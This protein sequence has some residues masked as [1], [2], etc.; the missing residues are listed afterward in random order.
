[1]SGTT[2]WAD[3]P[4]DVLIGIDDT[5][6]PTSR[7]TGWLAQQLL[8]ELGEQGLGTCAG[9]TR[10]QLLKDPRIP[11]TSHNSSACLAWCSAPGVGPE[12]LAEV[13]GGFLEE[14]SADGSDPGLAVA[15]PARLSAD[16]RTTLG[17]LGR[18]AKAEVLP[19]PLAREVAREV[20]VHLS[21]HG[22]TE[23]GVLGALA[24][25]GLH[26]GGGDGFFLWMP[27]T[28]ELPTSATYAELRSRVPIDA[29]CDPQEAE[30]APDD[31]L[32]LGDWVRPVLLAGR[33]VLLLRPQ[34]PDG[35]WMVAPRYQVR[36]H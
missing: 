28:R 32:E 23:D 33:A 16:D 5:D 12:Q 1:M 7:G 31:L 17:E 24:A 21:G 29:A 13:I 8:A 10:H 18:R 30:P 36:E 4:V 20:G 34:A 9:A 27:G 15:A 35:T 2:R 6:N 11:Y 19:V 3:A 25:V 22:G 26:L 14:R